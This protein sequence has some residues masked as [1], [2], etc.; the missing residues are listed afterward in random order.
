M[1]GTTPLEAAMAAAATYVKMLQ[2]KLQPFLLN[3]IQQ[4]LKDTSTFHHKHEKLQEMGANPD[5]VPAVCRTVGMKL[6]AV[7]EVSKSPGFKAL[8]DK[9]KGKI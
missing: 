4:V 6:Q 5:Y 2:K 3:L 9:L 1:Q 7:S 8:E